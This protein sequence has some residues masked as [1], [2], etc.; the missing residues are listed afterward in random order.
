MNDDVTAAAHGASPALRAQDERELFVFPV[1]LDRFIAR[2]QLPQ[3]LTHAEAGKIAQVV[4]AFADQP[5][6]L[7]A[8]ERASREDVDTNPSRLQPAAAGEAPVVRAVNQSNSVP[9]DSPGKGQ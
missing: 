4:L 9:K 8:V 3:N 6:G 2:L 7:S 1:P 5:R